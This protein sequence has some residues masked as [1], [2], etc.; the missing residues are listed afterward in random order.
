MNLL[1][2]ILLLQLAT[3]LAFSQAP[4]RNNPTGLPNQP[5]TLVLSL[6]TEVV[7][8]HPHDI[9]DGADMKIFAPYL[10]DV[11]LSKIDLAKACS[12]DW[13]RQ[14]PEPRLKAKLVSYFGLFSGEFAEGVPRSFQVKKTLTEKDGSFRVYVSLTSHE[15]PRTSW[16]VAVIV[17]SEKGHYVIDDVI[18]INDS[19]YPDFEVKPANRR[20]SEYL[21]AGCNGSNWSRSS[22]PNQP[23]SLVMNLYQK[24]IA[25]PPSGIPTGAD[26]K[27]FAPYMSKTL[28]HRIDVFLAC[29]AD[30]ERQD[31]ERM[32]KDPFPNK[33][34]FGLFESGIFSGGNERTE[35]RTFHIERTESEKD[36]SIRVYVRL[37]WEEKQDKEIW[38]VAAILVREDG[39]LVVDDVIYLR[40][41]TRQ[42]SVDYRLSGALSSGCDGPHWVGGRRNKQK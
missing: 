15:T 6:Y 5:D 41:V 18:Y 23:E 38:R 19:V 37:K 32:L 30:W 29:V 3:T 35:P 12:A 27:I 8:R 28:L 2:Y 25:R 21:S 33:A 31:Q 20:L 42:S 1:R 4:Q 17:L 13:D 24:V 22:L 36:G 26:W 34:P 16:R 7:A 10:S 9:P 11:L 40:D 14:N 39:R